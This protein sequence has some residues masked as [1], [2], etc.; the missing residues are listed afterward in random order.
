MHIDNQQRDP[1]LFV[2]FESSDNLESWH[3]PHPQTIVGYRP[4]IDMT[5]LTGVSGEYDGRRLLIFTAIYVP[6]QAVFVA[7]RYLAR[8]L[9]K[10]P[11]G[12]DDLLIFASLVL[13]TALGVISVCTK[14]TRR[15][16]CIN[17]GDF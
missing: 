13:Q 8:Y 11:W 14:D 12:L 2:T 6:A 3:I 15:T 9:V 5:A 17:I 1:N 7:L 4:S 16:Y 10:G